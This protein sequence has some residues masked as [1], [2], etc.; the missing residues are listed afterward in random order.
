MNSMNDL[1][2]M[3]I[4]E[5][6]Q[7][8]EFEFAGELKNRDAQVFQ[9]IN[10]KAA[11]DYYDV[12]SK[13]QYVPIF[14]NEKKYLSSLKL[15]NLRNNYLLENEPCYNNPLILFE[16]DRVDLLPLGPY[17]GSYMKYRLSDGTFNK[18]VFAY[19]TKD[20]YYNQ[21][22][23]LDTIEKKFNILLQAVPK[24]KHLKDDEDFFHFRIANLYI[25]LSGPDGG[26]EYEPELV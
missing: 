9:L 3:Y 17:Q 6:E 23:I 12:L 14:W 16:L 8:Q 1:A 25:D 26:S 15:L 20:R 11:I 5:F 22:D 21:E 2:N 13:G 10:L 18:E 7:E 4:R 19:E 24:P